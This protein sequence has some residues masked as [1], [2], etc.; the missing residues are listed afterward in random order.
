MTGAGP[1]AG[2]T[3]GVGVVVVDGGALLLVRR[4]HEPY[5]GTWAVPGGRVR[6]G[7]T[8]RAAAARE[9]AEETGLAVDVGPVVWVGE[10][11]GPGDPPAWHH[12]I[13]DFRAAVT[14]GMLAAG[15]DAADVRWVPVGELDALPLGPTM[16]ELAG[17]LGEA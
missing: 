12:V 3:V 7:E 4:G 17:L 14:G 13:V 10:T 6:R 9:A 16:R 15:D 1:G 11:I 2:P 8:L 5:R